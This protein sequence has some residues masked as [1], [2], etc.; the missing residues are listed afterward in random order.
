M[1]FHQ[2]TQ[3]N[4]TPSRPAPQ[5]PSSAYS[6]AFS[7]GSSYS[8]DYTGIGGSPLRKSDQGEFVRSGTV[9]WKEEGFASFIFLRKWLVLKDE[10]LSVH[11]SEV[12][13]DHPSI[14]PRSPHHPPSRHPRRP[15]STSRISQTSN[16]S[17]S[18]HTVYCW[19]PK[20][21]DTTYP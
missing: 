8:P 2:V 13:P 9:S 1:A 6:S 11:K 16:E 12:S 7:S 19:R 18:S 20:K 14:I 3:T 15:P 4:L 17:I 10:T 21:S 5:A